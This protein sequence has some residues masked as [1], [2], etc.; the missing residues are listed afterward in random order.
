MV[1]NKIIGLIFCIISNVIY[2]QVF[3]FSLLS[4]KIFVNT[5]TISIDTASINPKSFKVYNSKD[6]LQSLEYQLN[7]AKG[8]IIFYKIPNDTLIFKYHR[9]VIDFNKKYLLHPISLNRA[10]HQKSFYEPIEISNSQNK[11]SIFQG[12]SLN[13]TGS[14]SRGL[15]IGNNQDFSLNSNLNLQLSGMISPTMKILASVTDDNIPIQPQGNTQQLQDFDKVF[16]QVSEEK[17]NL[18]AGDFWVKNKEGYFLKYNKRGQG[19]YVKNKIKGKGNI[20]INTENSASISKGKFGRNVIQ[21]IEGNQGPY[22]LYGN[23]NESFII[24]LSGTENVYIDGTLLKRGQNNDYIIDYNTA[25]ISFTAKTLITKDKRIIVEFQYSDKNYARSLLQSSTVFEKNKSSFYIYAYAEQD[26][27]NQPLQQDFDLVDRLTLESIG[28]NIEMAIGSGI[29]SIGFNENSNMYEKIDS[30]GYEIYNYSK[31][32]QLA[33]YQLTFSNVGQGN[34]NYVIKENN[35][36]GRVYEW[37]APDTISNSVILK[38]GD[39]SPIKKLVTPKK[40][41][42]LSIGGKRNWSSSSLKYEISSSNMDLNTFSK[43]NN[44]DNIGFAGLINYESKKLNSNWLINQ[45]YKIESISKNYE[46]IERFREV[47]FERNWNIQQLIINEDQILS[48]AKINLK[49]I[50]NGLFQYGLNSFFIKNDFN[51]YKNDLKI[52][53][54]KKVYLNF[55]GSLLNSSGI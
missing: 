27:K 36:L 5:D 14:L 17:W 32:N 38:N 45:S 12:T 55:N 16:I 40:R 29:D 35:A 33:I 24:V 42:I 30:L 19:I 41:Q 49:H 22:R 23:E 4:K 13:R 25:E 54:N 1:K 10:N 52:K 26:S 50:E 48:S 15:M 39:Y 6:E 46:R 11:K 53:W 2:G 37:V 3:D 9:L 43:I 18:T 28:D 51:G 44:N 34:G 31:D 20:K 7:A 21:G 8:Q 47:E